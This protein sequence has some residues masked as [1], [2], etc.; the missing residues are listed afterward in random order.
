MNNQD[1]SFY[2]KHYYLTSCCG[3]EEFKSGNFL[4]VQNYKYLYRMT[5]GLEGKKVLDIGCGR[6]EMCFFAVTKNASK[7]VGIDFSQ[8]AI[9]LSEEERLKNFSNQDLSFKCMDALTMNLNE[10]FDVIILGDIVEHLYDDQLK[11]LFEVVDRHLSDDGRVVIHTMP[12]REFIWF[13]QVFKFLYYLLRGKRL[14]FETFESQS[15][16]THVNLMTKKRLLKHM[17]RFDTVAWYDFSHD[18]KLRKLLRKLGLAKFISGNLWAIAK[19]SSPRI[20]T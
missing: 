4:D 3:F 15:K 7:V 13:G 18:S 5:E 17:A 1:K 16:I 20:S 11:Q 10:K 12:T 9:D 2:S 8:D 14:R 6:G 19:K